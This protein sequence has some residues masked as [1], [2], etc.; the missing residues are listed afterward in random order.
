[1]VIKA[2]SGD[3]GFLIKNFYY[4]DGVF[5]F[6]ESGNFRHFK[7]LSCLQE[8][9]FFITIVV[10]SSFFAFCLSLDTTVLRSVKCSMPCKR[11]VF[12]YHILIIWRVSSSLRVSAHAQN[13]LPMSTDQTSLG[14]GAAERDL[15]RARE[16]RS[17]T[18]DLI[19]TW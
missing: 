3:G 6:H 15:E 18:V 7:S 4:D 16:L 2:C 9:L 13:E 17:G 8:E 19:I 12:Y 1:M 11:L 10:C 5:C 14:F